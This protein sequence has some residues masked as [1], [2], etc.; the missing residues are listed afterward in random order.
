MRYRILVI[1]DDPLFRSLILALLRKDY[2]VSVAGEGAE[3]YHKAVEHAPDLAVIDVQ[4][5]G[6]DG[7]KT[8]RA[9]RGHP[10]L[11]DVPVV[12]LTGDASRETVV[13][14]VQAGADDYVIKTT[15]QKQ[16]F[17]QKLE[18]LLA[19]RHKL[20]VPGGGAAVVAPVLPPGP[21]VPTATAAT[22]QEVLDSLPQTHPRL[23]PAAAELVGATAA[24]GSSSDSDRLQN[25][26]D[27]WE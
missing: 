9:F 24:S 26:I 21:S 3:G 13:A 10:S 25:I 22:R 23:M 4:M 19:G 12:M 16:E 27:D 11:V 8:L 17:L 18:R 2:I 5:P 20:A 6:W 15:F 7:L 1:D 14:A